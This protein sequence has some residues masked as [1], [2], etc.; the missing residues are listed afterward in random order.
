MRN[1]IAAIQHG[2]REVVG[3]R[4]AALFRAD[5]SAHNFHFQRTDAHAA[6]HDPVLTSDTRVISKLLIG[7]I[8]AG[9]GSARL[10]LEQT[11]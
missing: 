11:A 2:E 6:G 8:G 4:E 7:I 5:G 3:Q 1:G 10:Q 9:D